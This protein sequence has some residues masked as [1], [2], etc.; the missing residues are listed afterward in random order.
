MKTRDLVLAGLMIALAAILAQFPLFQSI[1]LDAMPAYFA[2]AAIGPVLGGFVGGVG[3][4]L[5][6]AVTGFPLSLPLHIV[7]AFTMFIS[8]Y[9]Y[10]F[11]RQRWHRLVAVGIGIIMNGPVSLGISAFVAS[12]LGGPF[13]GWPMFVALIPMLTLASIVNVVI[14]EVLFGLIGQRVGAGLGRTE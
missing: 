3:H 14:A 9:A 11:A 1:G 13:S 4:L 10:G 2:A 5:I 7:I 12:L 6:A 8:C